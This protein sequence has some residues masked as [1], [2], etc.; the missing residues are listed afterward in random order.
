VDQEAAVVAD[1]VGCVAAVAR[2]LRKRNLLAAAKKVWFAV[3]R[4]L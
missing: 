1:A 4:G 2:H 3:L